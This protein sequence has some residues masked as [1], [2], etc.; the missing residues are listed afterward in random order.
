MSSAIKFWL[1]FECTLQ[2]NHNAASGEIGNTFKMSSP[3]CSKCERWGHWEDIQNVPT[4]VFTMRPLGTLGGHSKCAHPWIHNV[5]RGKILNVLA[6]WPSKVSTMRPVGKS[7]GHSKCGH[8][9]GPPCGP[10][11]KW[12]CVHHVPTEEVGPKIGRASCRERV[13]LYV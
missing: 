11:E 5:N 13:C 4:N 7:G 1:H 3:M 12:K 8:P 2:C 9:M 10:W 6:M